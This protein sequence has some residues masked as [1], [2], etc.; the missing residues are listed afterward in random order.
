M[1][2]FLSVFKSIQRWEEDMM[3]T[4][5]L[6]WINY[7]GIPLSTWE[8]DC[9]SKIISR[10]GKL[11][12]IVEETKSFMRVDRARA[13]IYTSTPPSNHSF[14]QGYDKWKDPSSENGGGTYYND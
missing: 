4:N 10:V 14:E 11:M 2:L 7:Y 9:F 3:S 1:K 6:A 12:D 8:N 13:L 5:K